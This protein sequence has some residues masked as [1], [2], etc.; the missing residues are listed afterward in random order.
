M[1]SLTCCP[2]CNS[3]LGSEAQ[4][5]CPRCGEQLPGKAAATTLDARRTAGAAGKRRTALALLGIM[6][7]MAVMGLS[8]ALYS[9]KSRQERHPRPRIVPPPVAIARPADLPAL[10]YV[11]RHAPI[12]AGVQVAALLQDPAGK[13]LLEKPPRMLAAALKLIESPGVKL[14]EIDHVALTFRSAGVLAELVVIVRTRL[15]YDLERVSRAVQPATA[16]LFRKRPLFEYSAPLLGK[17]TLWGA[18]E[19]TLVLAGQLRL[20]G[21]AP[22]G[23]IADAETRLQD[24]PETPQPG[25]EHLLPTV[26]QLMDE[27]LPRQAMAWAVGDVERIPGLLTPLLL[28][29]PQSE[30][31]SL[32]RF[33]MAGFPQDGFTLIT[34]FFTGRQATARQLQATLEEIKLPAGMTN[35]VEGPPPAADAEGQWVTMQVRASSEALSA[36][37]GRGQGP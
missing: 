8:Y 7:M 37:G 20:D 27:R 23:N 15:P 5:R 35:R 22:E 29:A 26:A 12:V 34:S 17:T 36:L 19:Q 11:P 21:D 18:D 14:E 16:S 10:G 30:W 4:A 2:Y 1:D 9:A 33:A 24:I 13:A 31:L 28:A 6:A 3:G 32:K 25:T